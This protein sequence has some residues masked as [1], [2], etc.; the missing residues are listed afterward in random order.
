MKILI[1]ND[2]LVAGGAEM[3][4]IREKN[5]LEKNFHNVFYLS[6]DKQNNLE[7]YTKKNNFINIPI[8]NYGL[9]KI[10]NKLFFNRNLYK[11]IIK[12]IDKI[13][14]D[15]IHVNNLYLASKTQ[16]KALSNYSNTIQ[17]I[18][19]YSA[20]CPLNT[21]IKYDGSVCLGMKYNNCLLEC[22]KNIKLISAI[23]R[24]KKNNRCRIKSIKKYICPSE[25][26]TEYCKNHDYDIECIN[27]PFDFD[28]FTEF[29]KKANFK[30]K[31]YLYYGNISKEKGVLQLIDA[32]LKFK[33]NKENVELILAGKID[34]N[35]RKIIDFHIEVNNIKYLGYLNYKDMI[36]VLEEIYTIVVPSKWMENYPNTV[37][38]AKAM[39]T[40]VIGSNRGGIPEMIHDKRFIFDIDNIDDIIKVL[41][42]SYYIEIQ[43]Y[44]NITKLNKDQCKQNNN[45]DKYYDKII[46]KFKSIESKN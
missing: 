27:N 24:N 36:K 40:L 19:D 4:G 13:S 23:V 29:K 26:L 41:N 2:L 12:E 30:N 3:Q 15:I 43:E 42:N 20:V 44:N 25:K 35:I 11:N 46:K 10:V 28:K 33:E 45:I 39:D 16:Y 17:T 14:P 32:F 1:I 5:I 7:Q 38:E 9:K 31:K 37:L 8:E 22:G 6:F 18:R 34:D 21:C